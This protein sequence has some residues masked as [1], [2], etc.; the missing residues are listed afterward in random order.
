MSHTF[1]LDIPEEID[2]PLKKTAEQNGQS[3]ETLAVQWLT[4]A[5]QRLV[6]DPLEKFI[7]AF[8]SQETDWADHHD[9][10]LR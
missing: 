8:D 9:Q 7:G 1:T 4:V 5:V 2:E 3:P 6:D 10:Y